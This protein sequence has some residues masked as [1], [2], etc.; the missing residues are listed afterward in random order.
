MNN[1][2]Q[3]LYRLNRTRE[4]LEAFEAAHQLEPTTSIPL[5]AIARLRL[6]MEHDAV[7]AEAAL[8]KVVDLHPESPD[9]LHMLAWSHLG[10]RRFEEAEAGVRRV[11]ELDSRH[12]FGLPNLA[13]LLLRRGRAVEAVPIYRQ[14][15]E[16]PVQ[17][18]PAVSWDTL[19][20]ALALRA[21]GESDEADQLL[22]A[23][24]ELLQDADAMAT[25]PDPDVDGLE[26]I[27]LLAALGREDEAAARL[28]AI[29]LETVPAGRLGRVAEIF[30]LLGRSDEALGALERAI[31][32]GYGDIFFWSIMPAL[33]GLRDD[34]RFLAL[35]E[36][37][38]P[39]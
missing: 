30:T 29:D 26:T 16:T 5:W 15:L 12:R 22:A 39:D 2:G 21:A 19:S 38:S 31:A 11:L 17:P 24:I 25:D 3:L 20:L 33:A 10:Q 1:K 37:R 9:A 23:R 34:P 32:G 36:A 8:Q 27:V 4:A 35:T 13:H 28:G 6:F 7:G 14:L 18:E